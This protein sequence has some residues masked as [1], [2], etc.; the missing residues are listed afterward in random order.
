MTAA[1]V[2]EKASRL[3]PALLLAAAFALGGA[4]SVPSRAVLAVLLTALA[5]ALGRGFSEEAPPAPLLFFGW[6]GTAALFS[7]DPAV[8][9][10]AFSGYALAGVLFYLAAAGPDGRSGWLA[11]VKLL[12]ALS[13]AALLL[14]RLAGFPLHGLVGANPNYSAVFCAAAFAP[15][16]LEVSAGARFRVLAP[17]AA[18]A[19][20]L[21]AGILA[22]GSRGAA[23][24]AFFSGAAGLAYAGRWRWLAWFLAAAAGAAALLPSSVIADLLKLGDPRA[25]ARPRLWGAALRAASSAPLLGLGP[26]RFG[27]AFELFKFPYFDGI[28]Y[29]GHST[30]GA[31]GVL[32]DLAAE[33]GFPAALFFLAAAVPALARGRKEELPL[34]L[35]ALAVLLQGCVDMVFYSG[36]VLLLFWGSLGFASSGAAGP[37][38]R[39]ALPSAAALLLTILTAAALLGGT[40]GQARYR[41]EAASENMAGRDPALAAAVYA[42]ALLEEPFNALA[43]EGEGRAL[44]AAGDLRAAEALL[45]RAVSLEPYFYGA[46]LEL[47]SVYA[48]EGRGGLACALLRAAPAAPAAAPRNEYQRRLLERPADAGRTENA[49]CGKLKTGGATA[50]RRDRPWKATK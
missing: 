47:A 17:R 33:A 25:Y 11:A 39:R 24:A 44:A 40:G 35:C 30:P 1:A 12:G 27:A 7:P 43:A 18:L 14:Q 21:A 20:L 42:R 22:S 49:I 34:R 48:A 50:L 37:R 15:V 29:Y 38:W 2:R 6:L 32:F 41:E 13:A 5:A 10:P 45:G 28:S 23:L 26:G 4:R 8:S 31:H 46:R 19:L 16:F 36:A 3:G 9:L